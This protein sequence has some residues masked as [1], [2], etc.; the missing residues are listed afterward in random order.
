MKTL[1]GRKTLQFGSVAGAGHDGFRIIARKIGAQVRL[2][3]RP[4]NDLTDRFTLIVETLA[5]DKNPAPP[6]TLITR[7]ISLGRAYWSASDRG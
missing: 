3:S 2:Y 5:R 4:G 7:S 1:S 6:V